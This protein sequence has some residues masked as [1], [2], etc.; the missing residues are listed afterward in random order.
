MGEHK[1]SVKHW[2]GRIGIV[3]KAVS[4]FR[5]IFVSSGISRHCRGCFRIGKVSFG[6]IQAVVTDVVGVD[7]TRAGIDDVNDAKSGDVHIGVARDG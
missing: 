1:I 3:G 7:V 4:T 5:E 2:D 6:L